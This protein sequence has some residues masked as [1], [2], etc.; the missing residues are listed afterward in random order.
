MAIISFDKDKTVD[1]VPE[2]NGNRNEP[3]TVDGVQEAPCIVKLKYVPYAKVQEYAA[4]M[5]A[6]TNAAKDVTFSSEI[7]QA[8]QKK[9][10]LDSVQSVSGYIIDGEEVTSAEKFFD[11]ADAELIYEILKAMESSAKLTEGQI[12]NFEW[13]SGGPE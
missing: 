7:L 13:A 8:V 5:A 11:T 9:Q 10:F 2:Y 4:L 6:R 1:F 3:N 12:K